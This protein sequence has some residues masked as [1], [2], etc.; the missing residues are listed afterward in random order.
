MNEKLTGREIL[1]LDKGICP[2]CDTPSLLEGPRG[3]MSVN[4]KCGR[5][6]AKFN[7]VPGLAGAFGKERLSEPRPK[8]VE[9]TAAQEA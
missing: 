6:G 5:C 3:G 7:V 1:A 4:V 8:L 2:D 9:H